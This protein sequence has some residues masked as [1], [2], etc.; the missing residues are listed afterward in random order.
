MTNPVTGEVRMPIGED[1]YTLQFSYNTL[2]EL[3]E[4]ANGKSFAAIA[5]SLTNGN[6]FSATNLRLMTFMGLKAH[7]P[8]LTVK[9]VGPIIDKG[10]IKFVVDNVLRAF[11]LAFPDPDAKENP[12]KPGTGKA[13]NGTSLNT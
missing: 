6:T 13:L 5:A 8:D 9:D 2:C 1:V 10:T 3:E 4:A 11:Q 12:T 7:H